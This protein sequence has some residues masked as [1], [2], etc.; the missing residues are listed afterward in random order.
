[1]NRQ[2]LELEVAK[3]RFERLAIYWHQDLSQLHLAQGQG[4]EAFPEDSYKRLGKMRALKRLL[5][6]DS[7]TELGA[8]SVNL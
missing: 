2:N 7:H 6:R 3:S 1:M 4:F 8:S 5:N